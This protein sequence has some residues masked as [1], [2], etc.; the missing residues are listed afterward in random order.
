MRVLDPE[1][2]LRQSIIVAL[3]SD[4][5]FQF[6]HMCLARHARGGCGLQAA[7]EHQG[8]HAVPG[9]RRRGVRR[10]VHQE[11]RHAHRDLQGAPRF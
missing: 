6:L 4:A 3:L 10:D 7:A 9:G 2:K 11:G 5:L 1:N 8:R